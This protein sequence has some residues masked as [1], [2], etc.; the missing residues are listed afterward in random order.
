VFRFSPLVH[1]PPITTLSSAVAEERVV[2]EF[3]G[4]FRTAFGRLGQVGTGQELQQDQD[5]SSNDDVPFEV[6][7]GW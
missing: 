3:Q 2:P 1:S 4:T 6:I 7:G 5:G